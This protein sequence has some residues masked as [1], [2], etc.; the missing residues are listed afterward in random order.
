MGHFHRLGT[1]RTNTLKKPFRGQNINQLLVA[2]IHCRHEALAPRV[3]EDLR[4]LVSATLSAKPSACLSAVAITPLPFIIAKL[5][6]MINENESQLKMVTMVSS[7]GDLVKRKR[8]KQNDRR[9]RRSVDPEI[10]DEDMELPL[11]DEELSK[12][13]QR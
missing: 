12:W 13:G 1:S 11:P 10:V 9:K 4:T 2:V 5:F 7:G 6:S 8:K 3:R